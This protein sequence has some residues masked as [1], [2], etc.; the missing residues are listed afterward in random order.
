MRPAR[1]LPRKFASLLPS[2][3]L[4]G[5]GSGKNRP[6]KERVSWGFSFFLLVAGGGGGNE[7]SEAN[8]R[9]LPLRARLRDGRLLRS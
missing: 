2:R 3:E 5:G 7:P 4:R 8:T 1:E 9:P 6:R